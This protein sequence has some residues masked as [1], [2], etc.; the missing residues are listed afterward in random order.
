VITSATGGKLDYFLDRS[1]R[2]EAGACTGPRRGSEITIDV[3]N[4]APASGLPPY[5]TIFIDQ[6]GQR[7][8]TDSAVVVSLHGTRGASLLLATLDGQP[9]PF[10]HVETGPYLSVGSDEGVPVW[11]LYLELPR[12]KTRRLVLDLDEPVVPG[13]VRIPEQPMARPLKVS[14]TGPVCR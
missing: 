10:G 13:A 7:S 11:Y 6:R 9:L 2:Y 12:E 3:T 5:L 14:T 8:T 4:R 1:V